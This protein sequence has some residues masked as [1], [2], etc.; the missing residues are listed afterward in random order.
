M[1]LIIQLFIFTIISFN[2]FA[3]ITL[4]AC[5][6]LFDDQEF[7]FTQTGTDETGRAIFETTPITGDQPC[8]GIGVCEFQIAYNDTDSR[9]ELRADDG[10][11]DFSDTFLI[12]YNAA[13]STPNPP[14]TSLGV[15]VE[16]STTDTETPYCGGNGDSTIEILTGGVQS[17]LLGNSKEESADVFKLFPNPSSRLIT[18]ESTYKISNIQVVDLTGKTV[19]S[20]S[21]IYQNT[22][23]VRQLQTGFYI[24]KFEINGKDYFKKIGIK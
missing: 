21:K 23:D 19:L 10:N 11:G 16:N 9:W 14:D 7:I 1:K 5:Q 2:G 18:I 13:Q 22:L 8:S 17:E 4:N 6:A 3:Q 20:A 12:Y 24:A 15:W